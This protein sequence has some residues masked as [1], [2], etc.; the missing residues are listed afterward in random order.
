[1]TLNS[2]LLTPEDP[3]LCISTDCEQWL[4]GGD[5]KKNKTENDRERWMKRERENP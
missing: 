3:P 1:L 2:D 5:G 4:Y